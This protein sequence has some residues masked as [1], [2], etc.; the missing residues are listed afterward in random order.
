[1][2]ARWALYPCRIVIGSRP[3]HNKPW[4][5]PEQPIS[6]SHLSVIS[7]KDGLWF[8]VSQ[9]SH[10]LQVCIGRHREGAKR[11]GWCFSVNTCHQG[12]LSACHCEIRLSNSA[13][14]ITRC[15]FETPPKQ[16]NSPWTLFTPQSY[17]ED[18]N[19]ME[20]HVKDRGFDWGSRGVGLVWQKFSHMHRTFLHWL[21]AHLEKNVS[22]RC[23]KRKPRTVA[24]KTPQN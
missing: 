23:V 4:H 2:Q 11:N 12:C 24:K 18:W 19:K 8:Q 17:R 7:C 6:D 1:M 15:S 3:S 20:T 21:C 16:A 9:K 13:G 5:E 14:P 10:I 22:S